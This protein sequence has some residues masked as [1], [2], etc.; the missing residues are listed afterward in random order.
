M[1]MSQHGGREPAPGVAPW[2]PQP[3]FTCRQ[4]VAAGATPCERGRRDT[5]QLMR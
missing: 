5:N 3:G 2:T 4:D 1:E